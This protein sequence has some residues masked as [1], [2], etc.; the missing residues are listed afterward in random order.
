MKMPLILVALQTQNHV[1]ILIRAQKNPGLKS[2]TW[3]TRPAPAILAQNAY[4]GSAC[5]S[6]GILFVRECERPL[7]NA[8]LNLNLA[9]VV[10]LVCLLTCSCAVR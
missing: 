4:A 2:E 7:P 3:A 10:E 1:A 6:R 5:E 8:A 9:T